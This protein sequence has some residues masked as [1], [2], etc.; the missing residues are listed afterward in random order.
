MGKFAVFVLAAI[1]GFFAVSGVGGSGGGF[2]EG[3]MSD[4]QMEG[5]MRQ[6]RQITASES[7]ASSACSCVYEELD[8]RGLTLMDAL[9]SDFEEMSR[10]TRSCAVKYG[11]EVAP[12]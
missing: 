8:A 10:V 2:S 12:L 11:A 9:G 3:E 7:M 1:G 4:M 5:C 6:M